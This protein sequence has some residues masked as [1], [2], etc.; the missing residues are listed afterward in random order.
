M[1]CMFLECSHQGLWELLHELFLSFQE[2]W[3][4]WASKIMF[5]RKN[6]FPSVVLLINNLF[7]FCSVDVQ[8][9]IILGWVACFWPRNYCLQLSVVDTEAAI[10]NIHQCCAGGVCWESVACWVCL[11]VICVL[12]IHTNI[13]VFVGCALCY[14]ELWWIVGGGFKAQNWGMCCMQHRLDTVLFL[15]EYIR[16]PAAVH[17]PI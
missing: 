8:S 13:F 4:C 1:R 7:C 15:L 12:S 14:W 6:Y 3:L 17:V 11:W 10:M 9:G 16:V 2:C 5:P